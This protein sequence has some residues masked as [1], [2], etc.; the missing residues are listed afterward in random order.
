MFHL[1]DTECNSGRCWGNSNGKGFLVLD[2]SNPG[3]KFRATSSNNGD[4]QIPGVS[5]R[6]LAYHFFFDR[7]TGSGWDQSYVKLRGDSHKASAATG[8]LIC[9]S[10]ITLLEPNST[11]FGP[12]HT[13]IMQAA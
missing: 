5:I 10:R 1:L 8:K 13:L 7:H 9:F 4:D 12:F 6:S 11:G 3:G 2:G